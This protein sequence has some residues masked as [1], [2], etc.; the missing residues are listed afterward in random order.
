MCINSGRNKPRSHECG[1][2]NVTH[3]T[4][5]TTRRNAQV[6]NLTPMVQ[7]P[8]IPRQ[9][10]LQNIPSITQPPPQSFSAP[11]FYRPRVNANYSR[12]RGRRAHYRQ[13]EFSQ[14]YDMFE[15]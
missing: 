1:N 12:G 5:P 4:T 15:Q 10:P 9:T 11:A 2:D 6:P 7:A 3:V 14:F 13:R 8:G